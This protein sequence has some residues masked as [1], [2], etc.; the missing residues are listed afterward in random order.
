[1][2]DASPAPVEEPEEETAP[3]PPQKSEEEILAERRA[4][5]AAIKAK[6]EGSRSV[7]DTAPGTPN[8]ATGSQALS[9]ISTTAPSA[10]GTPSGVVNEAMSKVTLAGDPGTPTVSTPGPEFLQRGSA[11]PP[12]TS[13]ADQNFELA[14]DGEDDAKRGEI[15][16]NAAE[17]AGGDQINAADYD[18]SLDRREDERKRFGVDQAANGTNHHVNGQSGSAIDVDMEDEDEDDEADEES[19]EEDLDDMFAVALGGDE[20][21]PKKKKKKATG[22]KKT[23]ENAAQ[24]L[25]AP[26]VIVDAAADPEGYYRVILGERIDNGRYQV[27]S[28]LGQGMFANVV[29]ARVLKD[30]NGKD[31][32]VDGVA[33]E[34]LREV[35]IKI[36][37]SQESMYKAGLKE[38][39]ILQKLRALDPEDKKHIVKLERTFEHRGHL[40]LVFENLSM[41]LREVV[42]RFGK[43]VG[44][45]IRAVRA[46]AHQLFLAL[47]LLRKAN[48][49]HAD[50][51][52]DN[53]LV[54][55][56][57]NLIKL[58]DLGSA[59]DASENEITPYL[60]SRFY[61]AP[62]IILGV[63]YDPALDVWSIGCTLYELYTGKILFPGRSNNQMLRLMME[64]KGRF[65]TKIIKKAKFGETYFDE[66]GAF[67]SV[68]RDRLTGSDITRKI[69]IQKPTRDLR[70]RLMPSSSVK[71]ND[72]ET[73]MLANFID[74]LD[75]C[76]MLDPARRITPRE[77][78]SHPFIRG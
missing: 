48:I 17:P 31:L 78:L 77:A 14:K 68:E 21:K 47:S 53:I 33:P 66:L 5:R 44:L 11:S 56:Q 16:A 32:A 59:S 39:Q 3:T 4:R 26:N 43:D 8:P 19:E 55:E 75:K 15:I 1:M 2:A 27:F 41:N 45:N 49:M 37:R 9:T 72:E 60:V 61:R 25:G 58:C 57:K 46:Y 28:S 35:A 6:Y 50:I 71:L 67:E 69:H 30:E 12:P 24:T 7:V 10:S 51:K 34:S 73:K 38:A 54:N 63:P 65:N 76:L 74:L 13:A 23:K 70:A 18:P 52:P 20:E 62:E 29:R 64:L 40:C 22:K 42:K 36:I